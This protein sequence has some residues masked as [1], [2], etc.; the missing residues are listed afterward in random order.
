MR[1]LSNI[2]LTN[3]PTPWNRHLLEKTASQLV[4]KFP[5]ILWNWKV[6][7]RTHNSS[8]PVPNLNQFN[9]MPCGMFRNIQ[10]FYGEELLASHPSPNLHERPLSA[11][12]LHICRLFL[13]PRH[14]VVAR[15]NLSQN[16]FHWRLIFFF[17]VALRP[18]ASHGLLIYEISRSHTTTHHSR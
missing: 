11:I 8:P 1:L 7:Y 15:T 13:H 9:Q 17:P 10:S 14:S 5:R 12:T 2:E 16:C 18:I 4:K 3:W 6:H